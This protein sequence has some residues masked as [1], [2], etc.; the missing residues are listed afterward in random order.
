MNSQ[1]KTV[2]ALVLGLAFSVGAGAQQVFRTAGFEM[3]INSRGEIVRLAGPNG[4]RNYAPEGHPGHLVRIRDTGGVELAPAA[5]RTVKDAL[6]FT[7]AG[8]I[9][10]TVRAARRSGY[11]RFELV[12]VARPEK[13]DAVLWGP[14]TTTIGETVGEVVGVVRDRGYRLRHPDPE[15][16]D[17]RRP[18]GQR[19]RDD[20]GDDD[21]H[22]GAVRVEPAGFLRQ[23]GPGP[24]HDRLESVRERAG[25]GPAG[26]RAGGE[27]PCDLRRRGGRCP[28]PDRPG[29]SGPK[30]CPT[31]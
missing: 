13:I 5:V 23:P 9:E 20:R 24:G 22:P 26:I 6:T 30:A 12:K 3:A 27:R 25:Q 4:P 18:A 16:E 8:G 10:L 21:G 29:S 14:I 31:P 17:L 15:L 28:A 19:R 1:K 11:L 7:F 2:C